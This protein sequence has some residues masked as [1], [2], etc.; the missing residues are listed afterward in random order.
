MTFLPN[1]DDIIS[2]LKVLI[3]V[4]KCSNAKLAKVGLTKLSKNQFV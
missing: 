3:E 2:R 1:I 4:W